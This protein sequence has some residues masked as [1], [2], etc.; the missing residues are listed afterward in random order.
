MATDFGNAVSRRAVYERARALLQESD[1]ADGLPSFRKVASKVNKPVLENALLGTAASAFVEV[2]RPVPTFP[3][4][5]VRVVSASSLPEPRAPWCRVEVMG[6]NNSCFETPVAA[7]NPNPFWNFKSELGHYELGQSVLFTIRSEAKRNQ[8]IGCV[9]LPAEKFSK[10]GF[11]GDLKLDKTMRE[12][13]SHIKVVV[14]VVFRPLS[15]ASGNLFVRVLSGYHFNFPPTGDK[16][17]SPGYQVKLQYLSERHETGWA[18]RLR[19]PKWNEKDTNNKDNESR[20]YVDEYD[21]DAVLRV[22]IHGHQHSSDGDVLAVA[23][24]DVRQVRSNYLHKLFIPLKTTQEEQETPSGT[25]KPATEEPP[26]LAVEINFEPEVDYALVADEANSRAIEWYDLMKMITTDLES[27]SHLARE[28]RRAFMQRI[29]KIANL[30]KTLTLRRDDMHKVALGELADIIRKAIDE[31]TTEEVGRH[32]VVATGSREGNN[33]TVDAAGGE[34]V[35]P[36]KSTRRRS[37]FKPVM[38]RQQQGDRRSVFRQQTRRTQLSGAGLNQFQ[39][40]PLLVQE[41]AMEG[42]SLDISEEDPLKRASDILAKARLLTGGWGNQDP[43]ERASRIILASMTFVGGGVGQPRASHALGLAAGARPS[44]QAHSGLGGAGSGIGAGG[45]GG[46]RPSKSLSRGSQSL[47][48]GPPSASSTGPLAS[49][50]EEE[51]DHEEEH[52]ALAALRSLAG[53]GVAGLAQAEEPTG[54]SRVSQ[55]LAASRRLTLG[56]VPEGADGGGPTAG[57]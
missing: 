45:T 4:L 34:P 20:F 40:A 37:T 5:E 7:S 22:E 35:C 16:N 21:L 15:V 14:K 1:V 6:C 10:D 26:V 3:V 36:R 56:I 43:G 41:F 38:A 55:L 19:H 12:A 44:L 25:R 33:E 13:A 9:I 50:S 32:L 46:A 52:D 53:L 17:G 39:C 42:A 51:A 8:I 11:E 29:Q 49:H 30:F 24:L 2:T 57:G 23:D 27:K 28:A 18:K 47:G 54:S 31:E 48:G